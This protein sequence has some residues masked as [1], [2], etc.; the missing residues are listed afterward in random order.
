[1][2]DDSSASTELGDGEGSRILY[3]SESM[4]LYEISGSRD[5]KES[6]GSIDLQ[7]DPGSWILQTPEHFD[8]ISGSRD[9]MDLATRQGFGIRRSGGSREFQDSPGSQSFREI[10]GCDD[11]NDAFND[12]IASDYDAAPTSD[13]IKEKN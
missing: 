12:S 11:V 8:R 1:M 6:P 9:S 7:D 2:E 5:F 3:T 4:D 10:S 13:T